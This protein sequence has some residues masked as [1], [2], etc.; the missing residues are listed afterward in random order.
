MRPAGV[1]ELTRRERLKTVIYIPTIYQGD[2]DRAVV[3]EQKQYVWFRLL[4]KWMREQNDMR[5]IWKVGRFSHLED[6]VQYWR[7]DNIRY[8]NAPLMKE[9]KRADVAFTDTQSASCVLDCAK[10]DIPILVLIVQDDRGIVLDT[11]DIYHC[12]GKDLHH[13][14][15]W[16]EAQLTNSIGFT[17]PKRLVQ[18]KS[19]WLRIL[20]RDKDEWKQS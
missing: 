3:S 20:R 1:G 9:L 6:P 8:S 5:F 4:W 14:L 15:K 19:D 13:T 7:A 12:V 11:E 18:N 17:F 2:S 16:L 10:A